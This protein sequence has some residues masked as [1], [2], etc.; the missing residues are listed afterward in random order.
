MMAATVPTG[1]FEVLLLESGSVAAVGFC[2]AVWSELAV[3]TAA[4]FSTL[5]GI[6]AVVTFVAEVV[7]SRFAWRRSVVMASPPPSVKL[8]APIVCHE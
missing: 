4:I 1:R 6:C 2:D 5:L 7:S 8:A 3:G